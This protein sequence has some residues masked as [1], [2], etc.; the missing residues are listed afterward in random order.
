[1]GDEDPDEVVDAGDDASLIP[2]S[3]VGMACW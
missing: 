3:A 1:M 2:M